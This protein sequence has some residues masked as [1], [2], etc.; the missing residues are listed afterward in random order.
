MTYPDLLDDISELYDL[1]ADPGELRNLI[2]VPEYAEVTQM[3]QGR[4]EQQLSQTG[5]PFTAAAE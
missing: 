3:M 1:Q 2:N 4:L 5:Y